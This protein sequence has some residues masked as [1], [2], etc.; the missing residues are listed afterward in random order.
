MHGKPIRVAMLA[1]TCYLTDPRVRRQAEALAEYGADVHVVALSENPSELPERVRSQVN[2][3]WVYRLPITRRRGSMLRYVY[4]Y[5]LTAILGGIALTW[6]NTRGKLDV[7]H[8]HNMPDI[9]VIASIVPRLLGSKIVLDIHDPMPE[10]YMSRNHDSRSLLVRGLRLQERIGCRFADRVISVNDTMRETLIA[11]G[12]RSEKIFIVHNFPDHY[13]F[14]IVDLPSRWPRSPDVLELSYCGT[15]TAH[16]DLGL[17]VKAI[18]ELSGKV[19]IRLRILGDGNRISEVLNLASALKV[20][21]WI[22][23][24]SKVPIEKVAEEMRKADA[25]ISCHRAGVFGDL[26][27]STKLL[28]YLSQGLPVVTA[29]T[30]TVRRYLPDDTVFYFEP[31]NHLSLADQLRHMWENPGEVRVRMENARALLSKLSWQAE[32]PRLRE[33]YTSLQQQ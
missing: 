5:Q 22:E 25:G 30:Y 10:L 23:V 27:F 9:L 16:Y 6:L 26:Y 17:A 12:V 32:K 4:E 15:I 3:V 13:H 18:A 20:R 33:F 7:I 21:D 11:K 24:V 2:G 31:G 29:D 1:H 14:P 19:P 8:V 28:E